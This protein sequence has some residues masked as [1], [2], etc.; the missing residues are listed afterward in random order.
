M[1][2]P[3]KPTHLPTPTRDRTP[4]RKADRKA[5]RKADR[6]PEWCAPTA[7]QTYLRSKVS[8]P[9]S[10]AALAQCR[11]TTKDTWQE[12]RATAHLWG[13]RRHGTHD[14]NNGEHNRSAR[15]WVRQARGH[16]QRRAPFSVLSAVNTWPSHPL[17]RSGVYLTYLT[18][19]I[20]QDLID[21]TR[22]GARE[23]FWWEEK[24]SG[25]LSRERS[26]ACSADGTS[27]TS[28]LTYL[29]YLIPQDLIDQTRSGARERFWWEE[30]SSGPLSRERSY[31]CSADGTSR[32]SYLTY[33]IPHV[34]HTSSSTRKNPP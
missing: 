9:Q 34:P 23:R 29:T 1:S 31:A 3:G 27:R 14:E 16:E 4:G 12:R 10:I 18:Y 15:P 7:R 2:V 28:Y 32:T 17:G 19:L 33:L 20:P 6:K 26:Y 24:S 25:P 5:G 30:K 11:Q 21:Q 22:S 13:K 8:C